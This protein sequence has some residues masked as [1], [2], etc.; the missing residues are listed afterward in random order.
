[1]ED[2]IQPAINDALGW[3][4][5]SVH[6]NTSTQWTAELNKFSRSQYASSSSLMPTLMGN[7]SGSLQCV[8]Q[9]N[10][11][12]PAP[13]PKAATAG[14]PYSGNGYTSG[15]YCSGI[16]EYKAA[17]RF[18]SCP[19]TS[20][21]PAG[22]AELNA[23]SSF[24]MLVPRWQS[25]NG[26]GACI[27]LGQDNNIFDN[28]RCS[29]HP[30]GAEQCNDLAAMFLSLPAGECNTK[31]QQTGAL[32]A[33]ANLGAGAT[34]VLANAPAGTP[35]DQLA[36]LETQGD[37]NGEGGCKAKVWCSSAEEDRMEY[38][39]AGEDPSTHCC[40]VKPPR[41]APTSPDCSSSSSPATSLPTLL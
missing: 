10:I 35:D 37:A 18:P 24:G 27:Y 17:Y 21:S 12:Y 19:Y 20:T 30:N 25:N 32:G 15:W 28:G 7:S 11:L 23:S 36:V 38:C 39:A 16:D 41:C 8:P 29:A 33:C 13:T 22:W 4:V 1:M 34:C 26:Q 3:T 31:P 14:Y 2:I 9:Q 5:R 40:K 6:L